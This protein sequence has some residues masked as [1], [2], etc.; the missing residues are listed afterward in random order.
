MIKIKRKIIARVKSLFFNYFSLKEFQKIAITGLGS[1]QCIKKGFLPVAI[2]FYSP[3]P[4]I[5]DLE[6][7]DIWNKKSALSGINFNEQEQL[8]FLED[9][10]RN[11]GK[12]CNWPLFETE[13]K[14]DYFVYNNGF[15]FGCA[16]SLYSIIRKFKPKKIIEIGSGNS[17][18]IISQALKIN[19]EDG[20]KAHYTIIDPYPENYIYNK[21]VV[22]DEIIKEKVELMGIDFFSSLEEND[23]LFIDSSHSVKIGSD[24]NFLILDVL[25]RLK[26]GVIIH[27]HDIALPD[28]YSKAYATNEVFR[29][30]W[31][32][33]YLLQAFLIFNKE[34]KI[35]LGMHYMMKYH[36]QF[37]AKA[38]PYFDPNIH[39][40]GSGSF[41]IQ[42]I[43]K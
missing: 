16:A 33:Q 12:E 19:L 3:I 41:W 34:F 38:F 43:N 24:V 14:A 15:S 21:T 5:Y 23:I 39:K 37:F 1:N 17:S 40:Q 25:P 8:L 35:I 27:F 22:Y 28:E 32:E 7:R 13:N 6:K 36:P 18:K 9:I 26:P 10:S 42:R 31:T 20:F 29:Q 2:N 30:F 4:D 11:F